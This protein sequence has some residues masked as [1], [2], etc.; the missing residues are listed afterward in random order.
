MVVSLVL[1]CFAGAPKKKKK[2][3]HAI[4]SADKAWRR[5]N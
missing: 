3:N 4:V 5:F 1:G 2:K